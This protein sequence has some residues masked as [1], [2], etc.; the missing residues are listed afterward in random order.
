MTEYA[1][2]WENGSCLSYIVVPLKAPQ[3]ILWITYHVP[4]SPLLL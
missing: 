1:G 3:D 2:M 4:A